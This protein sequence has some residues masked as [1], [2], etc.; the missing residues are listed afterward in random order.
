MT[1]RSIYRA[2]NIKISVSRKAFSSSILSADSYPSDWLSNKAIKVSK[3]NQWKHRYT[4]DALASNIKPFIGYCS[5][6]YWNEVKYA[7]ENFTRAW[8]SD[9]TMT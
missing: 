2:I 7:A 1:L 3:R 4:Q 8:S 5:S 6:Q 9:F